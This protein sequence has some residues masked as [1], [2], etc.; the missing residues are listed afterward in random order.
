M[1][2]TFEVR[3]GHGLYSKPAVTT[4]D[5]GSAGITIPDAHTG[6]PWANSAYWVIVSSFVIVGT[7]LALSRTRR[8]Q[9]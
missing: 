8:E 2:F 5:V 3:D 4:I 7:G 9:T 6:E 1:N